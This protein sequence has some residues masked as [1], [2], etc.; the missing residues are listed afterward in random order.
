[1]YDAQI[2]G[3]GDQFPNA[4]YFVIEYHRSAVGRV[5]LMLCAQSQYSSQTAVY[6][7]WFCG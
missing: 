7:A 1:M 2:E 6:P 3:Y 4:M 5:P